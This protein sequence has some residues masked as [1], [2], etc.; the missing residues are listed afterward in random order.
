MTAPAV[1]D[2]DT[3]WRCLS[4][5]EDETRDLGRTLGAR[6]SGGE[7][8]ALVG[9]LGA[10]KTRFVQGLA[11]GLGVEPRRVASPTFAIRHDHVGRLALIHVDF[12]RLRDPDEVDRL[13][14]LETPDQAV[15]AIEWADRLPGILPPDRLDIVFSA[16]QGP[17]GRTLSW[18]ARGPRHERAL[19]A[20]RAVH[21]G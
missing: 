5:S 3:V 1:N 21:G 10:G 2:P 4:A 11:Q 16:A 20:I 19:A 13:G 8:L 18:T 17:D 7:V 12:Y 15:I 14:I 6:L 9:G